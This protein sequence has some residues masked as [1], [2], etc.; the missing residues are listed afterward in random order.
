MANNT[1]FTPA[2]FTR[3]ISGKAELYE[4]AIRNGFKLPSY[5]SGI[6]TETYITSVIL[7]EIYCP[8]YSDIRLLPCPRPPDKDTLIGYARQIKIPGNKSLGIGDDDHT[9]DKEWLLMLLS[10][11]KPDLKIFKKDYVAPPRVPKIDEKPSISLP[12]D[13]LK[14]LPVSR[15]KTKAKRLAIIS[16]GKTES[17]LE[18]TKTMVTKYKR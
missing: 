15:K 16:K 12:S 7:G 10:T 17:K 5:K 3:V 11:H 14:D 1:N 4:S 2:E 18:H 6:V 13:F 9:P 8:K